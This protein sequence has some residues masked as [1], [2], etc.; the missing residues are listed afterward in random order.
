MDL[1]IDAKKTIVLT[2]TNGA[3]ITELEGFYIAYAVENEQ[4]GT[5]NLYKDNE[6]NNSEGQLVAKV[7]IEIIN[8]KAEIS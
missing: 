5:Y 7:H 8:N 2:L 1:K 6:N 3:V 4:A